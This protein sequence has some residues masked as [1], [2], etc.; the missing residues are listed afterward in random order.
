MG[1]PATENV[2]LGCRFGQVCE[3]NQTAPAHIGNTQVAAS[4]IMELVFSFVQTSI[5]TAP[6]ILRTLHH[7]MS[8]ASGSGGGD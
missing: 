1:Q 5:I 4:P 8:T 7:S 2:V 3:S 6:M